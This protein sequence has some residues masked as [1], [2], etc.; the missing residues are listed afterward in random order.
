MSGLDFCR[1]KDV[2]ES[3]CPSG[4]RQARQD[5]MDEILCFV[6]AALPGDNIETFTEIH[7]VHKEDGAFCGEKGLYFLISIFFF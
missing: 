2:L 1:L 4:D 5:G 6:Q 7:L 3:I